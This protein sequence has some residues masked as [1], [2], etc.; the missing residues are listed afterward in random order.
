MSEFDHQLWS[1]LFGGKITP[2]SPAPAFIRRAVNAGV[3]QVSAP[4]RLGAGHGANPL[5]RARGLTENGS[6]F[7]ETPCPNPIFPAAV[8]P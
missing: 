1:T 5:A 8:S 7:L 6:S 2:P 3:A 4:R